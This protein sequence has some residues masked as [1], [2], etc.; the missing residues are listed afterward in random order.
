MLGATL[1]FSLVSISSNAQTP[2]P[3]DTS[4][5]L[6]TLENSPRTG[7]WVEVTRAD[8]PPIRTWVVYPE[9]DDKAA[10]VI[11]I[12]GNRGIVDWVRAAADRLAAAGFIVLA[13]DLLSGK[14][15]SGGG[16]TSLTSGDEARRLMGELTPEEIEGALN[17]AWAHTESLTRWSG[18]TATMGI[19]SGGGVAFRYATTQPALAATV[20][21][22]GPSPDTSA[23]AS[24]GAPVLGLYGGD[25]ARVNATIPEAAAEMVRLGKT[26]E[27]EIYDGAGHAFLQRQSERDG[28]NRA[29]T[30]KGWP[31]AIEFLERHLAQA[32]PGDPR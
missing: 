7:T 32:G 1:A 27:R 25:D 12:H 22:Y 18:K 30:E 8:A 6:Q 31:R 16:F 4:Q 21:F 13:P 15:P 23:L 2:L 19:C 9:G 26:Y 11:L 20:V 14:G 10:A 28:S 17:A 5:A 24:I 3:P 29:A